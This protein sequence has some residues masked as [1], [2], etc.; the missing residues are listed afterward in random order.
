MI[1]HELTNTYLLSFELLIES[2]YLCWRNS[3]CFESNLLNKSKLKDQIKSYGIY[4]H[5]HAIKKDIPINYT[6]NIEY[7]TLVWANKLTNPLTL[8]EPYEY[9]ELYNQVIDEIEIN[10]FKVKNRTE[11]IAYANIF[12]RNLDKSHISKCMFN[13]EERDIRY[14]AMFVLVLDYGFLV[15]DNV[16]K[17][18]ENYSRFVTKYN[19]CSRLIN[20]LDFIDKLIELFFCFE[21]DLS[22]LAEKSKYNL[23]ILNEDKTSNPNNYPIGQ[24][25]E[26]TLIVNENYSNKANY[27]NKAQNNILPKFTSTLSDDCLIKIMHYLANKNNLIKPNVDTWFFWFNRKYII[28]P[29]FLKWIGSPTMLS[30]IIQQICV[31]SNSTTLK[32]AFNTKVYVKP[33]KTKYEKC[34]MYK[35]IEQIITISK[36]K[37]I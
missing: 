34:R 21:I 5:K 2:L 15:D 4:D 33:T 12:L 1:T 32:T 35:E 6:D 37:S 3:F 25:L 11:R 10:L 14:K 8:Y 31:E 17:Q 24:S 19:L 23:H 30:N 22:E 16:L 27:C 13:S 7:Q 9:Y 36:Q 29:Q 20:H 26:N 18:G 28:L